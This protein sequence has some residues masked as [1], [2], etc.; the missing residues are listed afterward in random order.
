MRSWLID[1]ANRLTS[2]QIS[3]STDYILAIDLPCVPGKAPEVHLSKAF[4]PI[5]ESIEKDPVLWSKRLELMD[6]CQQIQKQADT[7]AP[8]ASVI[9]S[10]LPFPI[11]YLLVLYRNPDS[12][13]LA[14]LS[15]AAFQSSTHS[16]GFLVVDGKLAWS[17]DGINF[18]RRSLSDIGSNSSELLEALAKKERSESPLPTVA[19][20]GS[21]GLLTYSSIR[22]GWDLARLTYLPAVF[23]TVESS[24]TRAVY[25]ALGM[26]ALSL[27]IGR[28]LARNF[29]QSI[30]EFITSADR[31]GRGDFNLKLDES[32][33]DEFSQVRRA[34]NTLST[35][36]LRMTEELVQKAKLSFE[37]ST[38][39]EVQRL[40]LPPKELRI[41]GH[42]IFG[43]VSPAEY[44]GGDWWGFF[45][46]PR[47]DGTESH[48]ILM[49][50]VSGHG[51]GAALISATLRGFIAA[52]GSQARAHPELYL[53]PS[54]VL[55]SVSKMLL[56][57]TRGDFVA[58]GVAILLNPS[59][60]SLVISNAGHPPPY[61]LHSHDH[62]DAGK[63][64]ICLGEASPL[65]VVTVCV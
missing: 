51:T 30:Q 57:S 17:E 50:D 46:I 41:S 54:A 38:A 47:K 6:S 26:I 48:M 19:T 10:L 4:A 45:S 15:M 29:A 11:P 5:F 12:L 25:L 43:T 52:V 27:L 36:I 44:C 24:R 59:E 53:D 37:L 32:G 20:F 1:N 16:T 7:K 62:P 35:T 63:G 18:L 49:F 23:S 13:R 33:K 56:E 55:E 40:L 39:G 21:G 60:N 14:M 64:P 42:R 28:I 9:E 3:Q 31:V 34:L 22:P 61:L 65:L 2:E 58:T 8:P